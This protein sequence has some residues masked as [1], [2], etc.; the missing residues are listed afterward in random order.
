M[1]PVSVPGKL[2]LRT[3]PAAN[4]CLAK[5]LSLVHRERSNLGDYS[6]SATA[7]NEADLEQW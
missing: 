2:C 1:F 3:K 4:S 7:A 5:P 6:K